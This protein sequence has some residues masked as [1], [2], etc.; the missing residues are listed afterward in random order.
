VAFAP[1]MTP[2][3]QTQEEGSQDLAEVED[4]VD[5]TV[6]IGGCRAKANTAQVR[7]SWHQRVSELTAD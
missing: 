6:T 5:E 1:Y 7:S 3:T 2:A 4:F